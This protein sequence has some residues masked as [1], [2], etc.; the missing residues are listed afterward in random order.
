MSFYNINVLEDKSNRLAFYF[1]DD[2]QR[3][4][5][6]N[7]VSKKP[8]QDWTNADVHR[9]GEEGVTAYNVLTHITDP[10]TE[11]KEAVLTSFIDRLVAIREQKILY[12]GKDKEYDVDAGG[13]SSRGE[14]YPDFAGRVADRL[15]TQAK[16]NFAGRLTPELLG[17]IEAAY[18]YFKE[19]VDSR[20]KRHG[21]DTEQFNAIF[22]DAKYAELKRT[23][24]HPVAGHLTP[25][26]IGYF[27]AEV[28]GPEKRDALVTLFFEAVTASAENPMA[29]HLVDWYAKNMKKYSV[30]YNHELPPSLAAINEAGIAKFREVQPKK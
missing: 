9:G 8:L 12:T 30:T 23:L 21:R 13:V 25:K 14:R 26:H 15:V 28:E 5:Y 18:D 4:I 7:G 22:A 16:E 11:N 20:R 29:K 10:K 24:L 3:A 17:K 19:D 27:L 1:P 2:E 6:T